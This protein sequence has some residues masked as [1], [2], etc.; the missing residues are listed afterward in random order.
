SRRVGPVWRPGPALS[1]RRDAGR[2]AAAR[3][4]TSVDQY[5]KAACPARGGRRVRP[6]G[7]AEAVAPASLH[8]T[9]A[10]RTIT[11]GAAGLTPPPNPRHPPACPTDRG[12]RGRLRSAACVVVSGG[13]NRDPPRRRR[14]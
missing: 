6:G 11:I 12:L 2:H 7:G 3:P 5:G 9:R 8:A 14:P 13:T 1:T 4:S 10:G